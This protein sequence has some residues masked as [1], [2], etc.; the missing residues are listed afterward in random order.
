[1]VKQDD[2]NRGKVFTRRALIL[3]GGQ[4]AL[5]GVLAGR[6]Y[7]LQ[8]VEA[9]RYRMLAEDNRINLRLLPPPRGRVVDRF[10]RLIAVN[11]QT[12]Q[13]VLVRE[14]SPDL[15]EMLDALAQIIDMD[16]GE[17]N[18]IKRETMRKRGF[19]PVTVREN[20]TWEQV[21]RIEV[22]APDLPGIAIATGETRRYPFGA[23]MAQPLGY[24]GAVSERE[25]TGDPLLELPGFRI[26][27]IG[28]ERQ[29]DL[30]LRGGAGTSQVEVNA[31]GRVIRELSRDEGRPGNEL[32]LTIDA[33]LQNFVHQRLMGERAAAA[34]VMDV[35]D[36]DV[37]A[38]ASVPSYDP[39]AFSVG[40]TSSQWSSLI[41]DPLQP[42][43]NRATAGLYAPGSTFK[44]I[45]ALAALEAGIGPSYK[46]RCPGH[47]KLGTARFHCWKKHGHGRMSMR[48]ALKQSCDVYFY[49]VAYKTGIDRISAMARRFG[50]GDSVGLDVPGEKAGVIPTKDWKFA[51]FGETW[52]GGETLVTSIGQGFVLSTP[53]QLAVMT[54]RLSS[55]RRVTP[56]LARGFRDRPNAEAAEAAEAAPLFE[57]MG[58]PDA[59]MAII[60]DAMDAAVNEA[61]GTAFRKR[62]E[63]EGWEMA[64]K[65]GTSQVRRITLAERAAGVT[66][67]ED[68]PWRR[69][70]HA[71]FVGYAPVEN[72]RYC[73]A[74]VVEHGGGGSRVAA[75][76]ARDILI[77]TQQRDPAGPDAQ[78]QLVALPGGEG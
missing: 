74:V 45:V 6:M 68:L 35:T 12:Y 18:R 4:A 66:K 27:K 9:D 69:R 25:L 13:L 26:G 5:L 63:I 70:D 19:V 33:G 59:H 37:L 52:Q 1:M 41:S 40:L 2:S 51:N 60:R 46:V 24:V 7:Y 15:E 39:N 10:G 56:R 31:L 64:G 23:A 78:A 8:V 65:T 30:D 16:E 58:L 77:E 48:D 47:M 14:Q 42:L 53:L 71:L 29:Y 61:R 76:I 54:A 44:M 62:I 43:N 75:P 73:C 49:D 36:G 72:P 38:M 67:N 32:V 55:G 20:L 17:R 57:P 11:K 22:N 34:V 3:G 21:S 28:L 50:L